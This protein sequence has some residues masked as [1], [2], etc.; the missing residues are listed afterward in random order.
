MT[1]LVGAFGKWSKWFES[2]GIE[3]VVK[4]LLVVFFIILDFPLHQCLSNPV[5][6]L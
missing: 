4:D 2:A 5:S 1:V 6:G 3:I